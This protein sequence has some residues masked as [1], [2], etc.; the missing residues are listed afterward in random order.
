MGGSSEVE[1]WSDWHQ[2]A[3]MQGATQAADAQPNQTK[4]QQGAAKLRPHQV[5][6][7]SSE[8]ET[9]EQMQHQQQ[10]Q[11]R[12]CARRGHYIPPNTT[13]VRR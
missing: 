9:Q 1:P 3:A 11:R 8:T 5:T 6:N 13:N 12:P 10:E 7:T 4:G 2:L